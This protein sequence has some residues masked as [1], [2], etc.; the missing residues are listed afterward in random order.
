[1]RWYRLSARFVTVS[2]NVRDRVLFLL[3]QLCVPAVII[4]PTANANIVVSVGHGRLGLI[5]L[6]Q[7]R[8]LV[9]QLNFRLNAQHDFGYIFKTCCQ[10]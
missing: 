7:P 8:T 3:T 9:V 4:L 2:D 6:Y 10:T 1:M 5:T